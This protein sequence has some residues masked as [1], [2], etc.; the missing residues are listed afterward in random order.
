MG[1]PLCSAAG[2]AISGFDDESGA[3]RCEDQLG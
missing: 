3:A 1:G 2:A